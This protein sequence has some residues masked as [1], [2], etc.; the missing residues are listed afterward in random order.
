M[1]SGRESAVCLA[2]PVKRRE[3]EA[4]AEGKEKKQQ[5]IIG[6]KASRGGRHTC[7]AP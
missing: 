6:S 3:S 4:T 5:D 1:L 7:S 2:R